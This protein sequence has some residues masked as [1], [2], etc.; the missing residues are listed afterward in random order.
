MMAFVGMRDIPRTKTGIIIFN[1]L[2]D[3]LSV[4]NT[5]APSITFLKIHDL[6]ISRDKVEEHVVNIV[7]GS[8]GTFGIS[9]EA[10]ADS[11]GY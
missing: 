3:K 11:F 10:L 6:A 9:S 7:K 2:E 4:V 5:C 1:H 8:G